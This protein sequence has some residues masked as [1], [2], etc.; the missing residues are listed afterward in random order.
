MCG[1]FTQRPGFANAVRIA[2]AI[3]NGT[4][5]AV[6]PMRFASVIALDRNGARRA[7]RMRWGLVPGFARDPAETKPHIHARAETLDTKPTFRDS[8]LTRRGLVLVTSF[9][10]GEEV[11]PT[12]TQ[13]YVI[14]PEET[15]AIAVIWDRWNGEPPLLSFAMVTVEANPL[16]ATITD[17]MP[18]LI[19][20]HDWAKWLGE[21]SATVEELKV[22]LKPSQRE[23]TMQ[24]AGK[25]P[26]VKT[27][28]EMF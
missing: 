23:F 4:D 26:P 3:L 19:E 14:T 28:L 15:V 25:P 7:V 1:K 24:R 21:A 5:E 18:A 6:T 2:E 20:P 12:R 11:T 9:N 10:E 17:R 22:M 8:F 27:Q 13:Q 16:I